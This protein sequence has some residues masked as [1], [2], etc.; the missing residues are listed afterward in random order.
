MHRNN[1]IDLRTRMNENVVATFN[2]NLAA[3]KLEF[4]TTCD[5]LRNWPGGAAEEQ[6]FLEHKKQEL[7][8]ALMEHSFEN[9]SV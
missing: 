1:R 6:E 4:K 7:F 3:L 9:E 5:A 2:Y 8:R